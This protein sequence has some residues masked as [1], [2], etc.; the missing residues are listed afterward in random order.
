[1]LIG[2]SKHLAT[3]KEAASLDLLEFESMSVA[4]RS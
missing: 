4:F 1:M 2:N 3:G